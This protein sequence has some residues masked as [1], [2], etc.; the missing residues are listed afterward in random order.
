MT[1]VGLLVMGVLLSAF[2][3]WRPGAQSYVS[4]GTLEARCVRVMGKKLRVNP[5]DKSTYR[6]Q[7]SEIEAWVRP[8]SGDQNSLFN[9]AVGATVTASSS[10]E[11]L[12]W[13]TEKANDGFV[14]SEPGTLGWSSDSGLT[15][16]HVEWIALNLGA[17]YPIYRVVLYP[18]SDASAVGQGFPVD[19][20]I[21]ASSD[22]T[23]SAGWAT[24][25]SRINYPKPGDAGQAFALAAPGVRPAT[26]AP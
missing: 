19:F 23:C 21:Q 26:A 22:I 1:L 10:F 24:I 8:P 11:G 12:G 17:T 4:A 13:S 7:F 20:E 6:M 3:F 14:A 16:D 25:L 9:Q 2:R 18:R 5:T 15:V